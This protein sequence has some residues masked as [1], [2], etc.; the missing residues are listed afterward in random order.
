MSGT[1]ADEGA[2]IR[3][4]ADQNFRAAILE[5]LRRMRSE[6]DIQS[7]RDIGLADA[8]D[9]VVLAYA[10]EQGRVLLTHDKRTMPRHLDD[11]LRATPTGK[12]HPGGLLIPRRMATRLAIEEIP[13]IWEAS[14]PNEWQDRITFL[15]L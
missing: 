10:N 4:L 6:M 7:V 9:P 2:H 11:F 8:P 3:F 14:E 15:P 5:G 12:H 13:L 1:G